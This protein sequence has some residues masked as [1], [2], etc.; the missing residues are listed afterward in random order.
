MDMRKQVAHAHRLEVLARFLGSIVRKEL[1]HFV[2]DAQLP[3]RDGQAHGRGREALGERI[4]ERGE[5]P[6][7]KATTSPRPRRD[8][9]EPA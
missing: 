6:P 9:G 5:I 8:R 4:Q 3:F 7:D 1:E 2:I